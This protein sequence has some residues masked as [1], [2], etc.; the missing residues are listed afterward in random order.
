MIRSRRAAWVVVVSWIL[1][2]VLTSVFLPKLASVTSD[3]PNLFL[4]PST[5][6]VKASRALQAAFPA[7]GVP[8]IV[9]FRRPGGLTGADLDYAGKFGVPFVSPDRA[10]ALTIVELPA[11]AD[12][13]T[14]TA[15]VNGLRHQLA[16]S[17]SGLQH[18]VTGPAGILADAVGV[19]GG[20]DF[21]VLAATLVLVLI[22]LAI[23]YRAPLL[24]LIPIVAV[25][26]AYSVATGIIAL[27]AQVAG[28]PLD[29]QSAFFL[30]VLAFGAGTDYTLLLLSRYLE[31]LRTG[32]PV[33]EALPAALKSVRRAVV[34]SGGTVVLATSVLWFATLGTFH[35]LAP[36]LSIGI[37]LTV[38]AGLTLIPSLLLLAGRA[39]VWPR[40]LVA[41]AESRRLPW[42]RTA[43]LVSRRP[44][45]SAALAVVALLG[46]TA[47]LSAYT[48]R[49]NLIDDF[50]KPTDSAAGAAVLKDAFGAGSLAPATVYVA[51]ASD[52]Q[53]VADSLARLP[54]VATVAPPAF[55]PAAASISVT[56]KSD[57]YAPST[58]SRIPAIRSAAQA[59]AP[60]ATVLVGGDTASQYDT[61]A[62]ARRDTYQ[63]LPLLFLVVGLVLVVALRSVVLPAVLVAVNFLGFTAALGVVVLLERFVL[64]GVGLSPL[65]PIYIFV[66]LGALG[67]DYNI[68]LLTRISQE[69]ATAPGLREA[70]RRGVATTGGVITSAGSILAG[71]FAVLATLPIRDLV[72]TG[73]GVAVGVLLDAVVVRTLLVPALVIGLGRPGWWPFGLTRGRGGDG[74][75]PVQVA[76][77]T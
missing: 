33:A 34:L 47:G 3:D 59:A 61:L 51:P 22:L 28:F 66:F 16:A 50:L 32:L 56:L 36:V 72:D 60:G 67:A 6:S 76:A 25:G 57:P 77:T 21:R 5:E 75:V 48:E 46:L 41:P 58:I 64:H 44:A 74:S 43:S 29:A 45:I 12:T 26:V 73:A 7:A 37:A 15:R 18:N 20:A 31:L 68:F 24:G 27:L 70:T 30:T 11:G 1:A 39:A 17:P 8:A 49:F 19:F 69:T 14:I 4:P 63:L 71:T 35:A 62:A 38:V 2:A 23:V 55:S 53:V 42:E 54:Q 52:A 40:K 65:E 13:T 10:S 9:V